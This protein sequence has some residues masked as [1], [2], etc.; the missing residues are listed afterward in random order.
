MHER[1][2][3]ACDRVIIHEDSSFE[4]VQAYYGMK[5][6][7]A[8]MP[9]GPLSDQP[10]V[11]KGVARQRLGLPADG[12]VFAYIGTARPNR[13][14]RKAVESFLR[15]GSGDSLIVVASKGS[16]AY[17]RGMPRNARVVSMD[18]FLSAMDMR[19]VYCAADFVI[20]DAEEYLTSG[21]VRSAMSYAIPVIARAYGS[22]ADMARGAMVEIG[23]E[24]LTAAM[25][26]AEGMN[27]GER[28]ALSAAALARDRERSWKA[29]G[30]ALGKL[31]SEL[32]AD[33]RG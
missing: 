28:S 11:D 10:G 8:V 17:L 23:P 24:G 29:A 26:R 16:S 2:Y 32:L 6:P 20:N 3:E 21:V 12:T 19:D 13:N 9:I 27:P 22:T 15:L 5:K 30:A 14:P 25:R 4:A 18:R 33:A 1:L 7:Y 31:Y